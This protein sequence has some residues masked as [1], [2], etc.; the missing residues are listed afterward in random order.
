M[1]ALLFIH[2]HATAR[3]NDREA[4]LR[5]PQAELSTAIGRGLAIVEIWIFVLMAIVIG[6]LA[7][8]SYYRNQQRK[9]ELLALAARHG[10]RFQPGHDTGMDSRFG[11]FACL[12][13]GDARYAY[14]VLEGTYEKRSICAFDYH[15]ETYST[16]SKGKR[17]TH[18][19]QFSAAVLDADLPLKRL[20]IRPEGFFDKVTEFFGFDDIDFESNE[21]SNRFHVTSPD[22]RFAFDVLHQATMEFLLSA[23]RFT[24]ELAG[25]CILVYRT[26]CFDPEEFEQALQVAAGI[27]DRLPNYL[28]SEWKGAVR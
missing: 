6:A 4:A 17:Q 15:Y 23:P 26:S 2:R 21:F 22:R 20:L 28:L 12:Q 13:T 7:I 19:H 16:D 14:N 9:N 24:I 3:I 27:I 8:H 25:P 11:A 10:W 18:H 5:S 1:R